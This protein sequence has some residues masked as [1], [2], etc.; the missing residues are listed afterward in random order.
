MKKGQH[1]LIT[2][3]NGFI[4][5]KLRRRLSVEMVTCLDRSKHSLFDVETL[6]PLLQNVSV[7]YHLAG[8][9]A[10]SGFEPEPSELSKNNI[11]ATYNL[12]KAIRCYCTKP[13]LVVVLSTIHVY[14]KASKQFEETSELGPTSVYGMSKLAQ[15]FLIRQA[16]EMGLIR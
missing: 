2:G 16:T 4:G 14:K 1:I 9:S 3:A 8:V 6:Q 10:G 12:L 15:E 13:P 5:T 7:V 11:E